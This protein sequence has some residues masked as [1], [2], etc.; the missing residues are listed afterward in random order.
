MWQ[1]E[2][3]PIYES[4]KKPINLAEIFSVEW[5]IEQKLKKEQWW[6]KENDQRKLHILSHKVCI[7]W[8]HGL[9]YYPILHYIFIQN[10][11]VAHYF[12]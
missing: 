3:I 1:W 7:Q 6:Y 4:T 2:G 12:D 5:Y 10:I 9:P 11:D 8:T